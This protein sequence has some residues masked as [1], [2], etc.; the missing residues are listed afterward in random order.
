MIAG[1]GHSVDWN[2]QLR[3]VGRQ[4]VVICEEISGS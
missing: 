4:S 2:D 1:G 3:N